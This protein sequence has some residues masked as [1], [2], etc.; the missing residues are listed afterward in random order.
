MLNKSSNEREGNH[1][2]W[3]FLFPHR[4]DVRRRR[5]NVT[6]EEESFWIFFLQI[7][8]RV[9]EVTRRMKKAIRE[10]MREVFGAF[11]NSSQGVGC[12]KE[13][14]K[15]DVREEEGSFWSF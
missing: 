14:E 6:Q 12:N 11:S 10:R 15:G 3:S 8:H 2:I 9:E 1:E 5:R 13:D 4:V 7:P